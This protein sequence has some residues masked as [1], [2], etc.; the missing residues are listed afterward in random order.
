MNWLAPWFL[1]G[2]LAIGAPLWLHLRRRADRNVVA[3]PAMRFLPEAQVVEKAP[4]SLR[5]AFLFLL[6]CL[7]ALSLAAAFARPIFPGPAAPHIVN[8]RVYVLD[9]T[10]SNQANDGFSRARDEI[11]REIQKLEVSTQ[12]AVVVLRG[13]AEIVAGFG[14]DRSELVSRL[15]A[16]QPSAQRGSYLAAIRLANTLLE[17]SLGS[18]KEIIFYGDNQANQWAENVNAPP[19]LK[20]VDLRIAHEARA[21]SEDNAAVVTPQVERLFI[22]DGE[23]V[24]CRFSLVHSGNPGRATIVVESNRKE[25]LRKS[26]N[27]PELPQNVSFEAGWTD[28]PSEWVEG[29]VRIEHA[30]DALAADDQAFFAS[31]PLIEGRVALLTHSSY[32][33]TALAPAVSKGRWSAFEVDPTH[34]DNLLGGAKDPDVLVMD[35]SYLQSA[36]VR[37]LVDR[38]QKDGRGVLICTDR[39]TPIIAEAMQ[40][41]GFVVSEPVDSKEEPAGKF[42]TNH[43]VTAPFASPDLGNIFGV[44]FKNHLNLDCAGGTALLYTQ[45]GAPLLFETVHGAGRVIATAFA[46]DREQTNWVIDPTFVPFLD[47]A[48]A[49]L[50]P[51]SAR[52]S[53]LEPGALWHLQLLP[54]E[55]AKNAVLRSNG[56]VLE[57][58]EFG[59]AGEVNF[60]L[61]EKPGLYSVCFDSSPETERMAVINTRPEE[62]DLTYTVGSPPVIA[63][64]KI[65]GNKALHDSDSGAGTKSEQPED[66]D[67]LWWRLILAAFLFL[68]IE[69]VLA[70][71]KAR[72]SLAW[73]LQEN[74]QTRHSQ[75]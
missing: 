4:L 23:Q 69:S 12:A 18:R 32:I 25:V 44:S 27:V 14:E 34:P 8:S 56:A 61:P 60:R 67:K 39:E 74:K 65:D 29:S 38:L 75:V 57:T 59:T 72:S 43:P 66:R 41:L 49:R 68:L 5:D 17:K 42:L 22:G 55:S 58:K 46:F 52:V 54:N 36:A 3:F 53:W 73:R 24:H 37:S 21:A 7:A 20:G 10:L 40:Q 26:V 16:L 6:R 1:L 35:A 71:K 51:P 33:R 50:R 31:A 64:W 45:S 70:L 11:K 15:G 9:D 13:E 28:A 2:G 62:S 48:L 19:F 63:S 47:L 30:P